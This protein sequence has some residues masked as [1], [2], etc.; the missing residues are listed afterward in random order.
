MLCFIQLLFL[1]NKGYLSI[2]GFRVMKKSEKLMKLGLWEQGLDIRLENISV[3]MLKS[4]EKSNLPY[5]IIKNV[6]FENAL[7]RNARYLSMLLSASFSRRNNKQ[8][9]RTDRGTIEQ[10]FCQLT[11]KKLIMDNRR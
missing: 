2:P 9:L 10:F 6:V 5:Y 3:M 8:Q 7:Y 4:Q 1:G 11:A